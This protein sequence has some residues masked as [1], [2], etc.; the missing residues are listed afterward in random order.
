MRNRYFIKDFVRE[1]EFIFPTFLKKGHLAPP[2]IL[3]THHFIPC[4]QVW[5]CLHGGSWFFIFYLSQVSQDTHNQALIMSPYSLHIR[6]TQDWSPVRP[7]L[8]VTWVI[9]LTHLN[10]SFHAA[11]IQTVTPM[12]INSSKVIREHASLISK[13]FANVK[14]CNDYSC[15]LQVS[16]RDKY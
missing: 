16:A 9:Y 14:D 11:N 4:H 3:Y 8:A 13:H 12:P 1:R 7:L 15:C 6:Q 5:L 10:C 2:M